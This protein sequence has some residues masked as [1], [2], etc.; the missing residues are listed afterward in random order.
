MLKPSIVGK[1]QLKE[2]HLSKLPLQQ[3][4]GNKLHQKAARR[5]QRYLYWMAL[6]RC[7]SDSGYEKCCEDQAYHAKDS[8]YNPHRSTHRGFR[9]YPEVSLWALDEEGSKT[10][11]KNE[12]G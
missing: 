8:V 10:P 4:D 9:P 7:P 5:I 12:L 1:W 2:V 6:Q 11:M 3:R